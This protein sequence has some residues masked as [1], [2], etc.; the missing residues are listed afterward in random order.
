MVEL[1]Q[2]QLDSVAA[3]RER[4]RTATADRAEIPTQRLRTAAQG[5]TLGFGDEIEAGIRHPFNSANRAE[6]LSELQGGI[7]AY[8][9]ARPNESMAYELG[10]AVAPAILSRGRTAPASAASAG[11]NLVPQFMRGGGVLQRLMR[12]AAGGGGAGAAY[13]VGTGEGSATDRLA[14]APSGA[15]GGA[16]GGAV[17]TAALGAVS[18][19]TSK[20]VD[21]ARQRLGAGGT[22]AVTAE[23]QRLATESGKSVD[24]I[25]SDLSTGRIMAENSTLADAVRALARTTGGQAQADMQAGIQARAAA[26]FADAKTEIQRYLADDADDNV[27]R[28]VRRNDDTART[29][30]NAAYARFETGTVGQE[31]QDQLSSAIRA[32]PSVADDLQTALRARGAEPLFDMVEGAPVFRRSPTPIEA[33]I[34]RRSINDSTQAAFQRSAGTVGAAFGDVERGLRRSIDDGVEGMAGVRAE[35]SALRTAR[36]SFVAGQNSITAGA[37]QVQIDF[38]A[39]PTD[40]AISSYRAGFMDILRRKFQGQ[41]PASIM[42]QLRNETAEGVSGDKNLGLIFRT[43]FPDEPMDDVVR[44]ITIASQGQDMKA[45]LGG[46]GTAPTAAAAARA[47]NSFNAEEMAGAATGSLMDMGRVLRRFINRDGTN[48]TDAQSQEVVRVLLSE[49]PD[50]VRRAMTDQTGWGALDRAV[51]QTL[52]RLA[53]GGTRAATVGGAGVS[54]GL[55]GP[56]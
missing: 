46:S 2:A 10:G 17:G 1:T 34:V 48:L 20:L 56:Q 21:I 14:R 5:L 3:S 6:T 4:Q 36:D 37:D 54:T 32:V 12:G 23:L 42:A 31:V 8:Q 45:L 35:A 47:G 29:A 38:A 53:A 49:N 40:D 18:S 16:I 51:S 44:R 39:L 19:L 25:V 13:A 50:F 24:E 52:E 33:E 22:R 26:T 11:I 41:Q 30:E 55:L 27:R 15:V 7:K 28:L 43:V 9:A